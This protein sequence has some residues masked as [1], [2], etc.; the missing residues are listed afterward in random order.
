MQAADSA[1]LPVV[2]VTCLLPV[3]RYGAVKGFCLRFLLHFDHP[4]VRIA[5]DSLHHVLILRLFGLPFLWEMQE[6]GSLLTRVQRSDPEVPKTCADL[7]KRV[8]ESTVREALKWIS[9][10]SLET[11]RTFPANIKRS[12]VFQ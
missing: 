9:L 5:C 11:G 3:A 6:T 12:S 7:P 4:W 10:V 8:E 2:P 1:T